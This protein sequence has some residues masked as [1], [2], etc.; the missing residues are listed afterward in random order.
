VENP[1]GDFGIEHPALTST[2][3]KSR[4]GAIDIEFIS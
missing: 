2:L 1:D 4:H 3:Q